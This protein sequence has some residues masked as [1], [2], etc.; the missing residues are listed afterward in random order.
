MMQALLWFTSLTVFTLMLS[1][2][3]NQT[4]AQMLTAMHVAAMWQVQNT[5]NGAKHRYGYDGLDSLTIAAEAC[6]AEMAVAKWMD[7]FWCGKVGNGDAGDLTGM[8][9]RHTTHDGG[10]LIVHPGDNDLARFVLVTGSMGKY[11]LR[12]MIMGRDA[13]QTRYWKELQAGRP[14]YC[15]PQADLAPVERIGR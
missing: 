9:V 4:P 11:R 7:R 13:K 2:G 15:V 12:G 5:K 14:A 10:H 6:M 1:I 8:E 3:I